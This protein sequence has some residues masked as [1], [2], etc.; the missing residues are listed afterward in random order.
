MG[1]CSVLVYFISLIIR[2][3]FNLNRLPKVCFEFL[4]FMEAFYE[5]NIFIRVSWELYSVWD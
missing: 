4:S 3:M 1:F 2:K 5:K